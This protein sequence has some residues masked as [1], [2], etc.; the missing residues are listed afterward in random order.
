VAMMSR[1]P[2]MGNS[3]TMTTKKKKEYSVDESTH[4]KYALC[5]L[6]GIRVHDFENV[7]Y[8]D[9]RTPGAPFNDTRSRC[10]LCHEHFIIHGNDSSTRIKTLLAEHV[11]T[12]GHESRF[13]Q[14]VNFHERY[15]EE[16]IQSRIDKSRSLQQRANQLGLPRWRSHITVLVMKY[17]ETPL[18]TNDGLPICGQRHRWYNLTS[19]LVQYEQMERL[20]LVELAFIKARIKSLTVNKESNTCA[21]DDS[22]QVAFVSCGVVDIMP[23]IVQFLGK[24]NPVFD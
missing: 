12:K 1:R 11:R 10:R 21:D 23:R 5:S 3:R 24:P 4:R 18:E 8:F 9:T 13:M 7:P 15:V 19:Q 20:S 22:R 2:T 14:L 16:A 6:E 17:I